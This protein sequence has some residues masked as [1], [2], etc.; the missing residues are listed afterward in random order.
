M[1]MLKHADK[2][3]LLPHVHGCTGE[4]ATV[5]TDEWRSY[6]RVERRHHTVNHGEG[7][8]ARDADGDGIREVHINTIEGL[9]TTL[10]NFLRPFRGVHKKYLSGY[11]AMCE[12]AINLKRI[13]PAFS[14]S[15]VAMHSD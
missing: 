9:W 1:Q 5:Y 2:A 8:W 10:R 12:F 3:N 15:L 4:E 11:V 7:E 14:A 6:E 13:G